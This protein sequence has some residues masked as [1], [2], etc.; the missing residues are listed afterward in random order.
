MVRTVTSSYVR[1]LVFV[2]I[3]TSSNAL[4]VL[5][6]Y[7]LF[8]VCVWFVVSMNTQ[9]VNIVLMVVVL[10]CL[11]GDGHKGKVTKVESWTSTCPRSGAYVVW[12]NGVENLYRIG[13]E[14]M[15]GIV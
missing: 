8:V 7:L 13:F 15:V 2:V 3:T 9:Q 1:L 6:M 4:R 14:G 12:E 10:S 11:G 5:A